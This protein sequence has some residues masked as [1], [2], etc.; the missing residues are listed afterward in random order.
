MI[1]YDDCG[2]TVVVND[3]GDVLGRYA[4][5][6]LPIPTVT[7]FIEPGVYVSTHAA[8]GRVPLATAANRRPVRRP[9]A[10]RIGSGTV[11]GDFAVVYAGAFIGRDVCIGDHAVIREDTRI[12][13]GCVIG[14]KVDI[15]YGCTIADDVR[16]LNET[17]IAG[18]T[19][20]GE[21]SFIGPGVQTAN[22]PHVARFGLDDYRDRGQVA[23]VIGRK[24]FIGVGAI[25]LPGVKIGDGAVIAA[26]AVITR[27]VRPG[28]R[29]FAPGVRG[30]PH[31]PEINREEAFQEGGP[32]RID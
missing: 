2:T 30:T 29:I 20:I 19:V 11:V 22:D 5:A 26:G 25:L 6:P 8:L 14:T 27:D 32:R 12:G 4:G 18:G 24:V 28:E 17:Q 13:D 10:G 7:P 31:G 15:Q 1:A 9:T 16:I 23:P 3:H 21:G